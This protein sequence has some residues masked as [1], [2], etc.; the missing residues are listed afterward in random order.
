MHVKKGDKV[1]VIAGKEKGKSAT[2]VRAIP[3]ENKVV[4]EGLN[5][6]KKHKRANKQAGV[7]GAMVS[8]PMP[9]HASNV[10]LAEAK[11]APAPKAAKKTSAKKV[12]TK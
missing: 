4:L 11:S 2:V 1:L 6:V 3:T 7:A 8:I 5:L 9:L 12:S 10:K